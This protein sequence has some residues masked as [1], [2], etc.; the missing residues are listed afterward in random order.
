[1]KNSFCCRNC[2]YDENND[3][4]SNNSL[5]DHADNADNQ[6]SINLLYRIFH[7]FIS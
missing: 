7:S 4:K 1:M 3:V 2:F 5:D 6:Y